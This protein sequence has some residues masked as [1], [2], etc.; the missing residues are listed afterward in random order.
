MTLITLCE[1]HSLHNIHISGY[2]TAGKFGKFDSFQTFGK[3]KF[4]KVIDQPIG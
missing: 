3:R 2:R 4:G 1:T